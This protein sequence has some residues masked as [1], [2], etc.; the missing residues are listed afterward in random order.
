MEY[1][2][3]SPRTAFREVTTSWRWRLPVRTSSIPYFF[4]P[5]FFAVVLILLLAQAAC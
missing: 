5:A 2:S 1:Y 4:L 3:L